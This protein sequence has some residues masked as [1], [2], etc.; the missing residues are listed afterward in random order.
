[1]ESGYCFNLEKHLF[2]TVDKVVFIVFTAS[3]S[4]V[5]NHSALRV[6]GYFLY[7]V[8]HVSA[9]VSSK[10]SSY[11]THPNNMMGCGPAGLNDL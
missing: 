6:Q 9:S 11:L 8:L 5:V 1:M 3:G 4:L 10:F 2:T 7:R